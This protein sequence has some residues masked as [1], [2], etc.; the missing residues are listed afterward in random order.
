MGSDFLIFDI[1]RST[2]LDQNLQTSDVIVSDTIVK[3]RVALGVLDVESRVERDQELARIARL[4]AL[5]RMH[6]S[7][8]AVSVGQIDVYAFDDEIS[9]HVRVA[10]H[11][12]QVKRGEAFDVSLKR[13]GTRL[14]EKNTHGYVAT[15]GGPIQRCCL[16]LASYRINFSTH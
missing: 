9:D 1:Q 11:G 13:I 10:E 16:E 6:E 3:S 15:P 5:T 14:Y 8:H 2:T 7:G 4:H 12:G